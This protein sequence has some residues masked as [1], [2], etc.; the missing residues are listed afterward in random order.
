LI[1]NAVKPEGRE[2]EAEKGRGRNAKSFFE[3]ES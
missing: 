3:R 1:K 2:R